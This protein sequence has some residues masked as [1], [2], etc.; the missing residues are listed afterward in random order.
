MSV[1]EIEM[2]VCREVIDMSELDANKLWE[3]I[4][5][6]ISEEVKENEAIKSFGDCSVQLTYS[7]ISNNSLS[8]SNV[9]LDR[10]TL[11]LMSIPTLRVVIKEV[12]E[13][14]RCQA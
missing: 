8:Q 12:I 9:I 11:C 4:D 6:V 3:I 10:R 14:L 13:Y 2:P 1:H 7:R 5:L